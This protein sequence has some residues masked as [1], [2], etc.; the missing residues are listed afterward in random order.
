VTACLVQEVTDGHSNNQVRG[1]FRIKYER[2]L[3]R[4]GEFNVPHITDMYVCI[5]RQYIRWC[6]M[7]LYSQYKN[8][9]AGDCVATKTDMH[10]GFYIN[11]INGSYETNTHPVQMAH[12]QVSTEQKQQPGTETS[13]QAA[14]ILPLSWNSTVCITDLQVEWLMDVVWFLAG[15][16]NVYI[17]QVV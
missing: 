15:A 7:C 10:W 6:L 1:S 17:L 11:R 5:H 3:H 12:V 4:F 16:R 8:N 2:H 9:T 13:V 14:F